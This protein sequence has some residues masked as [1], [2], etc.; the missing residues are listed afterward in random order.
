MYDQNPD[1]DI[2]GCKK[3]ATWIMLADMEDA[4]S[5][6]CAGHLEKLRQSDPSRAILFG[7]LNQ[8]VIRESLNARAKENT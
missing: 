8:I 3:P 1:C 7:P 4:D 5:L 2:A 6:L